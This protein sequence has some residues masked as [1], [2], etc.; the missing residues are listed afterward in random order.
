MVSVIRLILLSLAAVA[1]AYAQTI[2]APISPDDVAPI[3]AAVRKLTREPLI[4]IESVLTFRPI[5]GA[6]FV[7]A[8]SPRPL[9][10]RTDRVGV[11]TGIPGHHGGNYYEVQKVFRRWKVVS[12]RQW[13]N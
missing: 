9:Y 10:E 3:R 11:R 1:G 2:S 4:E 12:T 7:H 13:Q 5:R 6:V 8:H